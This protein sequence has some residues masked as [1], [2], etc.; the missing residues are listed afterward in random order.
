MDKQWEYQVRIY[1]GDE[2]ATMARRDPDNP[3]MKP[4]ADILAKHHA[5]MKCQ[6]DAFADYVAE[7][8]KRGA[9]NYPL[10]AWTKATIENPEKQAKYLK[11]FTLYVDGNEVY[12]QPLADALESDL[13]PLVG[14]KLIT[15]LSKHDTNPANNPQPPAQYRK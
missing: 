15:R 3:T 14:G 5:T 12:A 1:L 8:E 4:L 2:L 7:A 9:E 6:F 10:Y 11:S 13:Q